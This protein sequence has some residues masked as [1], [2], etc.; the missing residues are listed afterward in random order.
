MPVESSPAV[1][2]VAETKCWAGGY[3]AGARRSSGVERDGSP[4]VVT[5]YSITS[6][7]PNL[8]QHAPGRRSQRTPNL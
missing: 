2:A 6:A 5:P 8:A 4:S 7:G 1:P 3:A